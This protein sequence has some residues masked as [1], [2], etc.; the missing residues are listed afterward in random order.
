MESSDRLQTFFAD[1]LSQLSDAS[2]QALDQSL[3]VPLL[4]V[5]FTGHPEQ[6]AEQKFR[7]TGNQARQFALSNL[8][9]KHFSELE[10]RVLE[11]LLKRFT[12]PSKLYKHLAQDYQIK[13]YVMPPYIS[14]T[15]DHMIGIFYRFYGIQVVE[16]FIEKSVLHVVDTFMTGASCKSKNPIWELNNLMATKRGD[17]KYSS[18]KSE[19]NTETQVIL[20]ARF[21]SHCTVFSHSR[22]STNKQKAKTA[23]CS[24]VLEFFRKH[25]DIFE[26][27]VAP[28]QND[29]GM[30]YPLPI[31]PEE[32]TLIQGP[33]QTPT[34]TSR[35]SN[36]AQFA[37]SN[38]PVQW[39]STDDGHTHI[40]PS[41]YNQ[42]IQLLSE[43]LLGGDA[44]E[45]EDVDMSD[46]TPT[47]RKRSKDRLSL[48]T[49]NQT[50]FIKQEPSMES[51]SQHLLNVI[52]QPSPTQ[53]TM[54]GS[55]QS[56]GNPLSQT[57]PYSA[58]GQQP[59]VT[60]EQ[61]LVPMQT[62]QDSQVANPQQ[63]HIL[64][65]QP[66]GIPVTNKT[67]NQD[68]KVLLFFR[69]IFMN[70]H[71]LLSQS[72]SL[73]GQ[74][75]SIFLS[76]VVQNQE[77]VFAESRAEQVGPSHA[78]LFTAEVILKSK[79]SSSVYLRTEGLAKR[80]KD[81]EQTAFFKLVQLL[82]T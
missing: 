13:S 79:Q 59:N 4:F 23:A 39:S 40:K 38:Q 71:R 80:K 41:D 64:K 49:N 27:L 81:A 25:P 29:T 22:T 11:A 70:Y 37:S 63:Q 78:P 42:S 52:K 62:T 54:A 31:P 55:I 47:K 2:G 30:V 56:L 76:L 3:T 43:L 21:G 36:A 82:C 50:P 46:G 24:D 10:D 48:E 20:E 61:P 12:D 72:L 51:E 74:C 45:N 28:A 8:L 69:K 57:N 68:E 75:K 16:K 58:L 14:N 73:P 65:V 33:P 19:D 44:A 66:N 7:F 17:I 67:L 15:L 35:P 18:T 53:S 77:K 26:Q 9:V 5:L 6:L 34:P 32:Y 60:L 1:T